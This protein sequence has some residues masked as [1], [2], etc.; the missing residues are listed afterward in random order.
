MQGYLM[1]IYIIRAYIS[2]SNTL[3]FYVLKITN[4]Y[5]ANLRIFY[6]L[7]SIK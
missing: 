7:S 6:Y 3:Y 2:V 5:L 1:L 4:I